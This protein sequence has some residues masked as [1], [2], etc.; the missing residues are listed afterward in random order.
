METTKGLEMSR[1]SHLRPLS[2]NSDS[3][4][5]PGMNTLMNQISWAN[6]RVKFYSQVNFWSKKN[7]SPNKVWLKTKI[8]M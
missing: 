2:L 4:I 5:N 8:E 3:P 1:F 6:G 7:L